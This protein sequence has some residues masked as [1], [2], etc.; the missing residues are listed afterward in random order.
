VEVRAKVADPADPAEP[1]DPV[2]P[3]DPAER[4][5]FEALYR[6][7]FSRLVSLAHGLSGSRSAAEELVQEAF[8]AAHRRWDRIG[9]Y[10]DPS[11]WLRRV[12]VNRSVSAV[13]RRVAEGV[14]M[15]RLGARREI[16]D[17][18]PDQDEVVWRAVRQLPRRQAQVVALYYV[19]DRSVAEIAAVLDLAE[20][21]V[22]ATLHQARQALAR[23]LGN[24]VGPAGPG[25]PAGTDSEEVTP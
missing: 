23:A 14:A 24:P 1:A 19:D 25:S 17:E 18:L 15:T 7:D 8:L 5:S 3:A 22:K 12:V 4:V 20:G 2:D 11:A 10:A 13:R 9:G 6:R 16:P 21:T